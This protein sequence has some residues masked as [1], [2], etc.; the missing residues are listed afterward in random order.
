MDVFFVNPTKKHYLMDIS[1][2]IRLA[3][4]SVKKNLTQLKRL[5][6]IIEETET[7]GGR[8]FPH[9]RA[10]RETK[11][12]KRQKIIHNLSAIFDS[13]LIEFIEEKLAPRSVLLFGSYL[14]GEDTE[15]SD[16]DVFIECGR[17]EVDTSP[18]ERKLGRKIEL[19]FNEAFD[20][21]PKELKN[22]IINGIV[23]SGFLEGYK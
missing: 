18:F 20:S 4:T 21:Y 6:L 8:N 10:H 13:G 1:R 19:H 12:F 2:T 9:Y 17:E 16:I 15:Q 3:H 5:G 11:A 14:R 23:L 7:R 22:N